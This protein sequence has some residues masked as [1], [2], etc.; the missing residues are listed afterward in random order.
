[1]DDRAVFYP[2][3]NGDI[4]LPNAS[5]DILYLNAG[6]GGLP[7]FLTNSA[8]DS[9]SFD[10]TVVKHGQDQGRNCD[11]AIPDKTY[12]LV[13]LRGTKQQS[14]TR[15][16]MAQALNHLKPGGFFVLAAANDAGGKRLS[17]DVQALG[18]S[19]VEFSKHKCRIVV[20]RNENAKDP[21][22]QET[23]ALQKAENTGFWSQPGLFSWDRFDTG[24]LL[25]RDHLPSDLKGKI[26]DFGCGYGFL[27][28]TILERTPGITNLYAIDVDHRAVTACAKNITD[29]RCQTIWD[30]LTQPINFKDKV[31]TIIMNPPFHQ[32]KDV[33][34]NLGQR[35]IQTAYEHLTNKGQLWM[36]ANAHLPYE[37]KLS[38][39]F[40]SHEKIAE[41]RGFKIIHAKR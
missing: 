37:K 4:P 27:S 23:G 24:S 13:F 39:L 7:D 21:G 19:P 30:D 31:D 17:S 32:Q 28:R 6:T 10:F 5:D 36:V 18:L 16:Y 8:L 14:E 41:Q 34:Y 33:A 35:F 38:S 15:W 20:T 25:L 22:W 3:T 11:V 29:P 2:F 9:Q 12:D 40:G 26:A 1:M